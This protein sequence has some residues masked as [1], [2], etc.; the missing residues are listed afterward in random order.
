[1]NYL[2]LVRHGEFDEGEENLNE[3]GREQIKNLAVKIE[4]CKALLYL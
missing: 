1:M 4:E 3:K 2:I